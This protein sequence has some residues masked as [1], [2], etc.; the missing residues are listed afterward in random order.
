MN[1][2]F[3]YKKAYPIGILSDDN[4]DFYW[5]SDEFSYLE[6]VFLKASLDILILTL[7]DIFS[8]N[9]PNYRILLSLFGCYY[10]DNY[11]HITSNK[12][13]REIKDIYS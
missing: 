2:D 1:Y 5:I 12:L 3:L 8:K 13:L 9:T 7:A 4:F 10:T 11:Y 6:N